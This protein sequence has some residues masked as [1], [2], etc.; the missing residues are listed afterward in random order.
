MTRRK[1]RREVCSNCGG[2]ENVQWRGFHLDL[3]MILLCGLCG[4]L[5]VTDFRMYKRL[6]GCC[7]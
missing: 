2:T 4:R 1:P 3:P 7:G 5:I 6:E